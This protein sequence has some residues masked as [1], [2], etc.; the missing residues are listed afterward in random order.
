VRH[1]LSTMRGRI[2]VI[3][4][5]VIFPCV[6]LISSEY[7]LTSTGKQHT[8]KLVAEYLIFGDSQDTLHDAVAEK[9]FVLTT[10]LRSVE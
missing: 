2:A 1:F 9:F 7:A 10:T 8:A 5:F 4:L 6:I 3:V